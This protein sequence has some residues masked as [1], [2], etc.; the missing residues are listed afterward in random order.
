VVKDY[1]SVDEGIRNAILAINNF[2]EPATSPH[3]RLAILKKTPW[4][5]HFIEAGY[6]TELAAAR[7]RRMGQ[8]AEYARDVTRRRFRW[9]L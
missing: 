8:A 2:Y 9:M 1:V 4:L 3:A 7:D 6:S 5:P